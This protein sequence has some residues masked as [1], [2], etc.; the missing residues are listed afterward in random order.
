MA[1]TGSS[2]FPCFDYLFLTIVMIILELLLTSFVDF[3]LIIPLKCAVQIL[4]LLQV[5]AAACKRLK[6]TVRILKAFYPLDPVN[7][8]FIECCIIKIYFEVGT[9][10][11][12]I[13]F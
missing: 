10:P 12:V 1:L 4:L 8:C 9:V 3:K 11:L 5:C 7:H 13:T 6:A 2:L